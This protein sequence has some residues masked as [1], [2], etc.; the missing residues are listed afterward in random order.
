[1]L[2]WLKK[3]PFFQVFAVCTFSVFMALMFFVFFTVYGGRYSGQTGLNMGKIQK[4]R[5]ESNP[6]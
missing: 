6:S 2:N 1:M 4:M 5:Y 3:F